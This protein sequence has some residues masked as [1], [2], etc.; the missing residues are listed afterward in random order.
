MDEELGYSSADAGEQVSGV[1]EGKLTAGQKLPE[2][3]K[4]QNDPPK[5]AKSGNALID[6]INSERR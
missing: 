4:V 3:E 2:E 6:L 1:S 5:E